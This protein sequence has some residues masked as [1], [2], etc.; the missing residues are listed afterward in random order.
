[1]RSLD[2]LVRPL[3]YLDFSM[4]YGRYWAIIDLLVFTIIF[5]GL[6]RAALRARLPGR[7]GQAASVGIGLSL[8]FGMVLLEHRR[9][10]NLR[11]FGPAAVVL[12]V[13]LFGLIIHGI[14]RHAGA[15]VKT[16]AASAYAAT[17]LVTGVTS[18]EAVQWLTG[19]SPLTLAIL[20]LGLVISIASL[21]GAMLPGASGSPSVQS[22]RRVFRPFRRDSPSVPR[23]RRSNPPEL[24]AA[25]RQIEELDERVLDD[26]RSALRA[27]RRC[28][29]RPESRRRIAAALLKLATNN[30]SILPKVKELA[31]R[32]AGLRRLDEAAFREDKKAWLCAQT[33]DEKTLLKKQLHA[34]IDRRKIEERL[35][36]LDESARR[37]TAAVS[38]C[39]R[40]S[41]RLLLLGQTDQALRELRVAVGTERKVRSLSK[42][43]QALAREL[44]ELAALEWR[45]EQ[46]RGRTNGN[47]APCL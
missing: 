12:V 29:G 16:A 44:D 9:G 8:S 42:E 27:V 39:L 30:Q 14:L 47:D 28:D 20:T 25:S 4:I 5:V 18:P 46:K 43:L 11:A 10:V 23:D 40:D 38:Q 19:R 6:S 3:R 22:F 7:G 45:L 13:L 1:M 41:A 2:E 36:K 33:K 21:G 34:D 31:A 17:V 24:D 35:A 37:H 32:V 26:T 15:P